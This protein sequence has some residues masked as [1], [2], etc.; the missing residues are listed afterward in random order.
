MLKSLYALM[1]IF[2]LSTGVHAKTPDGGTP[3]N[4]GICDT[5]VDHT[6]GLYGLCVAYCEAQDIDLLLDDPDQVSKAVPSEKIL[7]NY[8]R[9]KGAGDPDMP[10][11]Q[12]SCPC[13]TTEE[14]SYGSWGDRSEPFCFS[15]FTGG[16]SGTLTGL[17][18]GDNFGHR[19]LLIED[20][21]GNEGVSICLFR[22]NE[23]PVQRVFLVDD[24]EAIICAS[25]ALQTCDDHG[26]MINP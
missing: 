12:E 18:E 26:F 4:E 19:A 22:D 25:Q 13:W 21:R 23:V 24:D 20:F 6:P 5:L 15:S 3:A 17:A 2:F 1:G 10:C 11:I 9:K 16:V 7:E 14:V 8:N